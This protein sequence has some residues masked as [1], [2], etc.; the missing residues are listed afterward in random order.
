MIG[1]TILEERSFHRASTMA[2]RPRYAVQSPPPPACWQTKKRTL[3]ARC[4]RHRHVTQ[5]T[6][7]VESLTTTW[8]S[9]QSDA[10]HARKTLDLTKHLHANTFRAQDKRPKSNWKLRKHTYHGAV[11]CSKLTVYT[12]KQTGRCMTQ[13]TWIDP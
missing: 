2:D 7:T 9:T 8:I 5:Q 3:A 13:R 4:Y 1:E 11:N 10:S 12:E 6:N